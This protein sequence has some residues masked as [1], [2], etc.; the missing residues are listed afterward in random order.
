VLGAA[1]ARGCLEI[2]ELDEVLVLVA[3][4]LLGDGTRLFERRG[5]VEVDLERIGVE[6]EPV[7][8]HL[9]FRVLR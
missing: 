7:G 1:V 8:T 5:G 4:I 6:V 2:G 9:W 3:P